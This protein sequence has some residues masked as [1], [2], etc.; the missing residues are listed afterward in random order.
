MEFHNRLAASGYCNENP[1]KLHK[2]IK[3]K[4]MERYTFAV[5]LLSS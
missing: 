4:K 5:E 1:P 2:R 3:P